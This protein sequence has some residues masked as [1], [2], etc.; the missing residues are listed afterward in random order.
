MSAG[1]VIAELS[2]LIQTGHTGLFLKTWEEERWKGHLEVLCQ[3]TGYVLKEWSSSEVLSS[4]RILGDEVLRSLAVFLNDAKSATSGG[5]FLVN[6]LNFYWQN[7]LAARMIREALTEFAGSKKCL[8]G[9]GPSAVIPTELIKDV[10]EFELPLP[11]FEEL[12]GALDEI[13]SEEAKNSYASHEKVK[14]AMS[15]LGLTLTEAKRAFRSVTFQRRSFDEGMI[16]QLVHEKRHLLG[17]SKLLEFHDLQEGLDEVGGLENLKEWVQQRAQAF[18]PEAKERGVDQPKG[19]LLVGVQGCGKSLSARVIAKQLAFPL[20]RLDFGALLSS[21][22]GSSEENLREVIQLMDSIAPVVLWIEEMDKAFSGYQQDSFSDATVARMIGRFLT[23]MQE[24]TAP[25]FVVATANQV[26]HLP[27]ELLRRGRFDELF[28]IDLPNYHERKSILKIHLLRRQI[29]LE[30]VELDLLADQTEQYSGSELE[31]VVSAA[32]IEAYT[33]Q[34]AVTMKDLTQSREA[35]IPLAVTME[36]AIFNLREW[37][38]GRCRMATSDSRVMQAL[39]E[40]KR[41]GATPLDEGQSMKGQWA[42]YLERGDVGES[43]VAYTRYH[44][45]AM[46]GQLQKDFGAHLETTGTSSLCLGTDE[47]VVFWQHLDED[48]ALQIQKLIRLRRLFLHIVDVAQYQSAKMVL[49][50]PVLKALR[51][52]PLP[53]PVWLPCQLQIVPPSTGSGRLGKVNVIDDHKTS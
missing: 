11:T 31:Q 53:R 40:E 39:E 5:L 45:G 42:Q 18:L 17:G 44:K 30:N 3:R 21:E 34:H 50:L 37:A 29:D 51:D 20:V 2:R 9:I 22:R 38:R 6:D 16:G 49:K 13:L 41:R 10:F 15:V 47:F 48:F 14:L 12:S 46:F 8:L 26:T 4:D 33:R 19:V 1:N 23:W 52:L 7:A 27:P 43:I 35:T 24:H 36:D 25:V 28:F 32:S